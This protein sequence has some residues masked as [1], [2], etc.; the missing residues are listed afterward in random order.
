MPP[1]WAIAIASRDSV[2]VSIAALSSGT[3]TRMLRVTHDDT[4][5]CARQHL[6]M[7]RHQQHVVERER[8]RE[9][10]GNLVGVQDVGS[11][12]HA[13]PQR[14]RAAIVRCPCRAR[15]TVTSGD[16]APWH[17]LYFFPLPHGQGSLRPT[18]GSSRFTWRIDVVAAG[19]RRPRRVAAALG[20]AAAD[21]AERR[22][23]RRLR[24][25]QRDLLRRP[26]RRGRAHRRLAGA[27]SPRP[28]CSRHRYRT[29]SSSTRSL[30]AVKSAKLSFL[31]STSGSR[32]P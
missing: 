8:G 11:S 20:A 3:F 28:A 18:F 9:A 19:A 26:P 23:R 21:G 7:P 1:C 27:S 10:D 6:R 12:F 31:Y 25:V 4:S 16:H 22:R 15:P 29:I 32:W 17:F 14:Q 13:G 30:I 2:T 5:T 24:R